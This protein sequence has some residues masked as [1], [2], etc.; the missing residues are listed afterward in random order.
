MEKTCEVIEKP[1][2]VKEFFRSSYFWKPALGVILGGVGGFLYYHF[3]GCTSGNCDITS[4]IYSSI[5]FGAAMGLFITK[6]PCVSC[7]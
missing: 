4:N 3:V 2:N 1:K 6:S 5:I 7:R